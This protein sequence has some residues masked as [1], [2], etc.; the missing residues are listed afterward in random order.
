MKVKLKRVAFKK[1][2]NMVNPEFEFEHQ[3]HQVV[4]H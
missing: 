2:S 1:E 4:P 3:E